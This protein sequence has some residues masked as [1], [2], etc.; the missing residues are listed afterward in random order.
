MSK[1]AAIIGLAG[2]VLLQGSALFQIRKFMRVKRTEGVSVGFHF[3]IFFGLGCYLIY[4]ISIKDPLYI[5]SNSCGMALTGMNI[6]LYYKYRYSKEATISYSETLMGERG[7][8]DFR[9]GEAEES[10]V[11]D[12]GEWWHY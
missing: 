10:P 12:E 9:R 3:A 6:I 4:S 1:F 11:F 5:F 7:S 2:L 8:L